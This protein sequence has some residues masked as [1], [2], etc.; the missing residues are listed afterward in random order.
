MKFCPINKYLLI[1]K[2]EEKSNNAF[3]IPDDMEKK[4]N[5]FTL[6]KVLDVADDCEKLTPATKMPLVI[7]QT[8]GIEEIRVKDEIFFIISEKFVVGIVK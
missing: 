7:V 2:I 4:L 5:P 8:H 3:E 1:Q 6:V